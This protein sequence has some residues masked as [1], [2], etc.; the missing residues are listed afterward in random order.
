MSIKNILVPGA[1][2]GGD[3]ILDADTLQGTVSYC[4][5]HPME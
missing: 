2:P 3:T 5:K 1:A 4:E